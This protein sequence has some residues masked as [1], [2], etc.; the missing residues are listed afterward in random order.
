MDYSSPKHNSKEMA[1]PTRKGKIHLTILSPNSKTRISY[2]NKFNN[3]VVYYS[4]H[5]NNNYKSKYKNKYLSTEERLTYQK[6]K[7]YLSRLKKPMG[8][9]SNNKILVYENKLKINLNRKL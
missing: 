8:F 9:E 4:N 5:K 1:T 2:V 7:H 3:N 6:N